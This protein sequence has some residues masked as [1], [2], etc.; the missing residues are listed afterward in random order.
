MLKIIQ[1]TQ[2]ER[3]E[4]S[5]ELAVIHPHLFFSVAGTDFK[6]S[7]VSTPSGATFPYFTPFCFLLPRKLA[8]RTDE[9]LPDESDEQEPSA[10]MLHRKT[11]SVDWFL[12][13][14]VRREFFKLASF[15]DSR[16]LETT[17]PFSAGP[18]PGP[19]ADG[20]S[21]DSDISRR[22]PRFLGTAPFLKISDPRTRKSQ[23]HYLEIGWK[24]SA[25]GLIS[26]LW[27]LQIAFPVIWIWGE[28]SK[29]VEKSRGFCPLFKGAREEHE[30]GEDGRKRM[31]KYRWVFGGF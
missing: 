23:L 17:A 26:P 31:P 27:V 15:A 2:K 7:D 4:D 19:F 3:I 1:I 25:T 28:F 30:R 5:P 8:D 16:P 18:E 21:I 6:I 20:D 22:N 9:K 10:E 29:T 13:T 12:E 24:A 11:E 14:L